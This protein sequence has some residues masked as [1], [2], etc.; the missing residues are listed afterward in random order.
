MFKGMTRPVTVA[1]VPQ[2]VLVVLL[3]T[4]ILGACLVFL[5]GLSAF[6]ALAVVGVVVLLWIAARVECERDPLAFRYMWLK[7]AASRRITTQ[8]YWGGNRSLAANPMRKR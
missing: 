8:R 4:M 3:L 6:F 7:F 1:G 5:L 2:V